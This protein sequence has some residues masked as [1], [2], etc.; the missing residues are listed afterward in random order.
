M[1]STSNMSCDSLLG[2]TNMVYIYDV[3][4]DPEIVL[5]AHVIS[6]PSKFTII[7]LTAARAHNTT[8]TALNLLPMNIT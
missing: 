5:T 7:H 1:T 8:N 4:G 3:A 2:S 6:I